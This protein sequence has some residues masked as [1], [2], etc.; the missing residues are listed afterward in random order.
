MSSWLTNPAG[1][2]LTRNVTPDF[3]GVSSAVWDCFRAD[4]NHAYIVWHSTVPAA[5]NRIGEWV[6]L[7]GSPVVPTR[8][9]LPGE[10]GR[11]KRMADAKLAVVALEYAPPAQV[12]PETAAQIDPHLQEI[13][14][15]TDMADEDL[16]DAIN[17][18]LVTLPPPSQKA[19][20]AGGSKKAAGIKSVVA[21]KGKAKPAETA[22]PVEA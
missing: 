3:P 1:I 15:G 14:D 2:T 9:P 18:G 10:A 16:Q 8:T 7:T 5:G 19:K 21:R 11:F 6:V 4:G 13:A 17:E 22:E 12:E 20:K